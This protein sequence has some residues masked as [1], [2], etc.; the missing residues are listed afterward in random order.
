MVFCLLIIAIGMIPLECTLNVGTV[1]DSV[2]I[3][4]G[5]DEIDEIKIAST[6]F[7]YGIQGV[8]GDS[9]AVKLRGERYARN[10]ENGESDLDVL[11]KIDEN[12]TAE[13]VVSVDAST[14]W[15][16]YCRP[17]FMDVSIACP[18]NLK[19]DLQLLQYRVC[20]DGMYGYQKVQV[21]TVYRD[22]EPDD[23]SNKK[24]EGIDSVGIGVVDGCAVNARSCRI[25]E[26][27]V[28]KDSLSFQSIV[29]NGPPECTKIHLPEHFDAWVDLQVSKTGRITIDGT[30]WDGA[31]YKNTINAGMNDAR[32]I[33]VRSVDSIA[34][35]FY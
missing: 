10:G 16:L 27:T 9:I 30:R 33:S 7:D 20:I 24:N 28:L 22:Y 17:R 26:I 31:M 1:F 29:V 19:C 15:V 21:G 25:V 2:V 18:R 14:D 32:V 35:D 4:R 3:V 34:V 6:R 13:P 8:E 11:W 12:G 23:P 5:A